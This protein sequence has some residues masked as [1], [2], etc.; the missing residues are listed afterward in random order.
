MSSHVVSRMYRP[1]EVILRESFYDQAVDVWSLGCCL[2][3][4]LACINIS[5][6]GEKQPNNTEKG[7]LFP[8]TSCYP[9]SPCSEALFSNE[10]V[11]I[12]HGK[13]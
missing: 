10:D 1:P 6:D 4:M 3:E 2:G 8:G 11:N 9:L 7:K 5:H 12:I 13:D